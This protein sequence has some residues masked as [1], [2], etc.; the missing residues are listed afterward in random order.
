MEEDTH[1]PCNLFG[2]ALTQI[3]LREFGEKFRHKN[4]DFRRLKEL[5]VF[6]NLTHPHG[7]AINI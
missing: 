6:L 7:I 1:H 2:R 4:I 3:T 5:F